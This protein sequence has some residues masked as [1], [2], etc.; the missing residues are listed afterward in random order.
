M[1]KIEERVERSLRV[2]EGW[3]AQRP[4]GRTQDLLRMIREEM[5]ALEALTPRALSDHPAKRLIERWQQLALKVKL[6]MN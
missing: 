1:T 2:L 6:G 5:N 4:R 3:E